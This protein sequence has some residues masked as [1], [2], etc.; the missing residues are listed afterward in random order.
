MLLRAIPVALALAAAA[1]TGA[2]ANP[3]EILFLGNSFTHGRYDPVRNYNAGFGANDVHDLLCP[4]AAT[5]TEPSV[6]VDPALNP[7]PGATLGAQLNYLST[8]PNAQYN[9]TGPEGGIPGIFLQFTREAGLD[10][11]VSILAVSS[12]SLTGYTTGTSKAYAPQ[13]ESAKW[14][15]VVLQ[16]QSFE[17][18]PN[19]I[20]VNGQSV[21]T[22]GNFAKFETGVNQIVAGV[23][24]A[25]A[26]AGKPSAA[27][28]LYETQPLASYA[29]TSNNP[30]QPIFG[31]STSAPGG[32]NAPYVG[33]PDPL[34]AMAGDLH[35][36]YEKAAADEMSANPAGS[37]LGVALAGDAWITAMN[38][39]IA[40]RDPYLLNEPAGRVDLW[41]SDPLDACCTTPVGYHQSTYGAYLNALVL[42]DEI[43]GVNPETLN[44]EFVPGDPNSAAAALGISPEIARALARAAYRTV[45]AGGPV[46][47]PASLAVLGAALAALGA[48]RQVVKRR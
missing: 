1:A 23:D 43:T 12:A 32:P 8:N 5:C 28:T 14:D 17:P 19:P 47:E 37:R 34:G 22:R 13:I 6:Q 20:Q 30:N 46:P 10:Y 44:G 41:D 35:N 39:G 38:E 9:E 40:Q 3:I 2:M 27:V 7:P 48:L 16:D 4:T 42:F 24:A 11:D 29:Y 25:D 18:L 45:Q 36:A 33:D 21:A 26:A 31:S 15:H